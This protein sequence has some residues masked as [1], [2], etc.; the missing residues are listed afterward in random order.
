MAVKSSSECIETVADLQ[1][2]GNKI[3]SYDTDE[4]EGEDL[5][6][7]NMLESLTILYQ[8]CK[9]PSLDGKTLAILGEVSQNREK[10]R[11]SDKANTYDRFF[12][13]Y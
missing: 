4:E 7:L 13:D 11:L 12:Y 1:G 9:C 2:I 5:I 6:S 10:I 3:I 8:V